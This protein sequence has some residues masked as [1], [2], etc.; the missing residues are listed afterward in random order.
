MRPLPGGRPSKAHGRKVRPRTK[1]SQ[2]Y[3]GGYNVEATSVRVRNSRKVGVAAK[4]SARR[5][6]PRRSIHAEVSVALGVDIM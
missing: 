1:K 4:F 2:W 6:A 5:F 3:A